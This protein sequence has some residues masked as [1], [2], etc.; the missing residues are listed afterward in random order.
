MDGDIEE[1]MSRLKERNKCIPGYS[2]EEIIAR[3]DN[4]DRK[5]GELVKRTKDT[6]DLVVYE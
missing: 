4:S 1:C 6:A 2:E 3:V 5:N